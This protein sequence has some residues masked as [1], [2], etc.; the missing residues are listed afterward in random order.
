MNASPSFSVIMFHG[1]LMSTLSLT[2]CDVGIVKYAPEA[3]V[4]SVVSVNFI[5]KEMLAYTRSKIRV[6]FFDKSLQKR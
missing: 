5:I 6:S 3:E 4:M 1:A 2:H